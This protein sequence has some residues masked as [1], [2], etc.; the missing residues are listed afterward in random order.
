[1]HIEVILDKSQ[2]TE[3]YSSA[4]FLAN[5]GDVPAQFT[6]QQSS[7]SVIGA[8]ADTTS[9]ITSLGGGSFK[10]VKTLGANPTFYRLRRIY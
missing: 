3:H 1:M 8:Y 6:L 9:T 7:P 5:S 10:A 4:T 2:R